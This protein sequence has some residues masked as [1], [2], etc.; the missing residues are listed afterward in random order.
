MAKNGE[1]EGVIGELRLQVEGWQSEVNPW[2][3][4]ENFKKNKKIK[5]KMRMKMKKNE[6]FGGG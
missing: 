2:K 1:I 3:N 4:L 6:K 5:N